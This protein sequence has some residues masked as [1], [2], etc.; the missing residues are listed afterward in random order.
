[1]Q[2]IHRPAAAVALG[3]ALGLVVPVTA[4]T[5]QDTGHVVVVFDTVGS[6]N[7]AVPADVCHIVIEAQGAAGGNGDPGGDQ[8]PGEGARVAGAAIDVIGGETLEVRVGGRGADAVS[9]QGPGGE[10]GFNGGGAG[11]SVQASEGTQRAGGG[12][13]GAS[14]VRRG[15]E[16]TGRLV[17][18]G[19]G[20]GTGG[21]P[22]TLAGGNGGPDGTDGADAGNTTGGKGGTQTAGG[23]AGENND[24]TFTAQPGALGVGG[25]GAATVDGVY[26]AGGGGGGGGFYGGGGGGAARSGFGPGSGG[27]GGSSLAPASATVETGVR[28]GDGTVTISYDPDAQ[29]DCPPPP[30]SSTSTSA[31]PTTSTTA[32]ALPVVT[33]RFTG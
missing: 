8:F 22:Q 2:K 19:G 32:A 24:D 12:G 33:P 29:D 17:V 20:A 13:G 16:L 5:A 9:G 11:G 31:A 1:M 27:G 7:F 23:A 15:A 10:G 14:D 18:A 4:A 28:E 25:F 3:A 26:N 6:A 30:T 21:F